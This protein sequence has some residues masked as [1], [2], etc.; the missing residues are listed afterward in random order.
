[1]KYRTATMMLIAIAGLAVTAGCDKKVDITFTNAT[2]KVLE[3]SLNGTAKEGTGLLGALNG[4]GSQ[5]KTRL[6]IS[7]SDLPV[8]Y[9]WTAGPYGGGFTITKKI[10]YWA[11]DVGSDRP[12]RSK[13]TVVHERK[14]KNWTETTTE[15]VVTP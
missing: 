14:E 9:R 7:K 15:E 4:R 1:M 11:V 2:D 8:H 12:P 13:K 3:V 6:K 10:K 5:I